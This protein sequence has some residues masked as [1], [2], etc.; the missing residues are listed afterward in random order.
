MSKMINF[1]DLKTI[2]NII[3]TIKKMNIFDNYY[4]EFLL[5]AARGFEW[6]CENGHINVAQWLYGLGGINIHADD[7]YA[8]RSCCQ[9]GH[10]NVAQ[11]LYGLGGINIHANEYAFKYSCDS[12]HINVAQW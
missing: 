12:G 4:K 2:S 7:E 11:W 9:N 1:L 5:K 10:I 8:F 3:L 6:N